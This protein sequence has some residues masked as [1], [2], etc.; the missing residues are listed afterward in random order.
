M[1]K[2]SLGAIVGATLLAASSA[3]SAGGYDG[4]RHHGGHQH[5]HG[6]NASFYI[7]FGSH[8]NV[9]YGIRYNSP[10]VY[11]RP[12]RAWRP[13]T[14]QHYSYN[15]RPHRSHQRIVHRSRGYCPQHNGWHR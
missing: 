9:S 15:N 10:R 6:N 11:A 5:H 8:G 3:A 13:V 2:I 1:K 12:H 4:N 14:Y 7:G